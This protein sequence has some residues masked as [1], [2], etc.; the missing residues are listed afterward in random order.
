M[1]QY[2]KIKVGI[3][4]FSVEE[5]DIPRIAEAMKHND[6]VQLECGLFRGNA[7]LAVCRDEE[8]EKKER[9]LVAFNSTESVEERQKREEENKITEKKKEQRINCEICG[10]TG[11]KEELREKSVVRVP[12]ECQLL[13]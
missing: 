13:N 7:I 3:E 8:R 9:T 1:N 6:M 12:C 2:Y 4:E 5:K 11:W 10:H